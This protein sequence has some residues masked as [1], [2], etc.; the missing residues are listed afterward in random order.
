MFS[1]GGNSARAFS[2]G[3]NGLGEFRHG[4]NSQAEFP[5]GENSAV[6]SDSNAPSSTEPRKRKGAGR[7]RKVPSERRTKRYT[8]TVNEIEKGTI[9]KAAR[10]AGLSPAEFLRA[11]GTGARL[12][13]RKGDVLYHRLSRIGVRLQRLAHRAGAEGRTE[14]HNA[15]DAL[16]QEVID[17]RGT[18]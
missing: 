12:A 18:L 13:K 9:E 2:P 6:R 15:L 14:E 4:D 17:V 7:P 8:V 10:E 3:Q 5:P 16:L 1:H 11:S